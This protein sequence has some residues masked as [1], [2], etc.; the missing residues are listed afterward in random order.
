[1]TT[2]E[3]TTVQTSVKVNIN[4]LYYALKGLEPIVSRDEFRPSIGGIHIDVRDRVVRL[5]ATDGYRLAYMDLASENV[6]VGRREA[7]LPLA[8]V[9]GAAR[10]LWPF[11]RSALANDSLSI[12]VGADGNVKLG[13]EELILQ[14]PVI[15][16][17][18]FRCPDYSSYDFAFDENSAP[19]YH[20]KAEYL[21][22]GAKFFQRIANDELGDPIIRVQGGRDQFSP[23]LITVPNP[24]AEGV[25]TAKYILMKFK[26]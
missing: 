16:G 15:K 21:V 17:G 1:M 3:K 5:M 7:F 4:A 12:N 24:L 26:P 19:P 22:Q 18:D 8:D 6:Q 23:V 25:E 11:V 20:V 14:I 10:R 2:E 9:Q 13:N